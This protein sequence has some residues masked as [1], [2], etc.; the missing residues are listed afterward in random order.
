MIITSAAANPDSKNFYL[1]VKGEVE[2]ALEG[3]GFTSLDIVQPGLLLG[4]R[5]EISSARAAGD[6][7]SCR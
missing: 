2:K 1:S 4:F 3:M 6:R 7:S 5:K